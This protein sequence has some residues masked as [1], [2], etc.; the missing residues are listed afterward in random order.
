MYEKVL[1]ILILI[2]SIVLVFFWLNYK[3]IPDSSFVEFNKNNDTYITVNNEKIKLEENENKYF[4][5][6][7]LNEGTYAIDIEGENLDNCE[8]IIYYNNRKNYISYNIDIK[9]D[10]HVRLYIN[11]NKKLKDFEINIHNTD[12]VLANVENIEI[13][14]YKEFNYLLLNNFACDKC[15]DENNERIIFPNGRSFGPGIKL[16]KGAYII[17]IYG[18]NLENA[19]IFLFTGNNIFVKNNMYYSISDFDN[20]HV[21]IYF[22]TNKKLSSFEVNV[23]NTKKENI[24]LKQ[25]KIRPVDEITD[26]INYNFPQN[27]KLILI[28]NEDEH[29]LN[30]IELLKTIIKKKIN[31]INLHNSPIIKSI[32]PIIY[33]NSLVYTNIN[34]KDKYKHYKQYIIGNS[35]FVSKYKQKFLENEKFIEHFD[36]KFEGKNYIEKGYDKDNIRYIEPGGHSWEPY[37]NLKKGKYLVN[38][39]G[40]NLNK[41]TYEVLAFEGKQ[42]IQSNVVKNTASNVYFLFS[43]TDNAENLELTVINESKKITKLSSMSIIPID[44]IKLKVKTD[45]KIKRVIQFEE[46]QI[47]N[48]DLHLYLFKNNSKIITVNYSPLYFR[49]IFPYLNNIIFV[50]DKKFI[51]YFYN[52]DFYYYKDQNNVI[53]SKNKIKGLP[54]YTFNNR[55]N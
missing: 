45:K 6:K 10:N 55:V 4:E 38:I 30:N 40:E 5:L 17:D 34:K 14:P 49:L 50:V 41:N 8:Y 1:K 52:K 3:V 24:I 23:E 32:F 33:K 44:E 13:S 11:T 26:D 47:K 9:N 28:D 54:V 48:C 35:F 51:N 20:N 46:K 29:N 39:N 7:E 16:N 37:V 21:Q 53:I 19:F 22:V 42:F 2:F 36:F 25:I 31:V 43:I 27:I 18:D 12:E 15:K